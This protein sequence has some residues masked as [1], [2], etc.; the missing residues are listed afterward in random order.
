MNTKYYYCEILAFHEPLE[1]QLPLKDAIKRY[2]YKE[3]AL[4]KYGGLAKE[5][6]F[7]GVQKRHNGKREW[8]INNTGDTQ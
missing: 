2:K 3:Q 1:Q 6:S 5:L 8:I 7:I 4:N